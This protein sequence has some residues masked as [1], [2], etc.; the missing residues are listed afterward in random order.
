MKP[1][2]DELRSRL[3]YEPETG[4]LYWRDGEKFAGRRA[5]VAVTKRGYHA[6]TFRPRAGKQTSLSA[7]RVAWAIYHGE[8][9]SGQIDHINGDKLDNRILNLRD[10]SN[11]VNAKNM[12]L[13]SN[14]K[15]GVPGVFRH[16][17][18]G[19]WSAQI[20]N[21]EKTIGLGC[22]D[23]FG[24]AVIA[25]KAAERALGYHQNHGRTK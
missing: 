10:V 17:Q 22:F 23:S 24:D 9:P 3:R 4:L 6:T 7:H 16:S 14:N 1:T 13:K 12:A 21:G 8:W 20:N 19:K 11:A 18:T 15:S 25:R 5:F 2:P